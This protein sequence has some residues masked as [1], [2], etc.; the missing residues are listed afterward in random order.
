MKATMLPFF[1]RTSAGWMLL[2]NR[3]VEKIIGRLNSQFAP[4][5][6]VNAMSEQ[7]HTSEYS[8]II[9]RRSLSM[10]GGCRGIQPR[11][12]QSLSLA[13]SFVAANPSFRFCGIR[14][15]AERRSTGAGIGFLEVPW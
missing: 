11:R 13:S 9:M 12:C 5:S 3:E 15:A 14:P 7:S 10:I 4:P 2:V 1:L 6:S 8:P